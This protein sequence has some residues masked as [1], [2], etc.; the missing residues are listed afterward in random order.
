MP[1][2]VT[3]QDVKDIFDTNMD[4]SFVEAFIRSAS[5]IVNNCPATV[6]ISPALSED[7]LFELERWV[8]AHLAAIRDPVSLRSKIGDA[9]AW[10]FPAAVTTAWAKGLSL[11]PYGQQ[12]LAID[13][14]G[15]LANSGKARA[16]YRV[17][18][19]EN[20]INFTEVLT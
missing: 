6:A 16:S 10:H 4:D 13:R 3:V 15:F 17:S 9:E 19:R 7:E 2:R 1:A 12:A 8:S 5:I 11:T 18:P 20:S 14:T